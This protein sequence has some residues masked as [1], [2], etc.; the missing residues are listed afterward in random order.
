MDLVFSYFVVFLLTCYSCIASNSA[1]D[2]QEKLN[3]AIL[4]GKHYFNIPVDNYE[5][6]KSDFIIASAYN[7]VIKAEIG[8]ILT[9]YPGYGVT[10]HG[11]RNITISGFGV[12]SNPAAFTQ[13]VI[14]N[15]NEKQLMIEIIL[16]DSFP[17]PDPIL[18][19][20]FANNSET[21]V[22]FWDASTKEIIQ[23]QPMYTPLKSFKQIGPRLYQIFIDTLPK[24]PKIGDMVTIS[25]RIW[26]DI[27]RPVPTFYKGVYQVYDSYNVISKNVSI[28]GGGNMGILEWGGDG[29]H[30]YDN[31][32]LIRRPNPPYP[33]RLLSSNLDAF[34]SF[35]LKRGSLITNCEFAYMGDDFVNLHNRVFI[36]LKVITTTKG[37]TEVQFVDPTDALPDLQG[38]SMVSTV[39]YINVGEVLSFYHINSRK[40]LGAGIIATRPKKLSDPTIVESARKLFTIINEPPYSANILPV[41]LKDIGVYQVSFTT[42]LV[43]PIKE[44]ET[45]IQYDSHSSMGTVIRDSYFHNSYCNTMRLQASNTIIFNNTFEHAAL[46]FNIVF[47][48]PWLEGSLG[49]HNVSIIGNTLK[50]IGGCTDE[51]S[52]FNIDPDIKDVTIKD[53][54]II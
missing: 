5:F 38:N 50:S 46:G 47:D 43:K 31:V 22:I 29:G 48:Q 7:L 32:K 15:I 16:S 34:H 23:G 11:C 25:P 1:R 42:P 8:A 37:I 3:D 2:L 39:R 52:C 10:I 26:S 33:F 17:S 13:G 27:H 51:K 24:V 35:S 49:I 54:K 20:Y 12:D 14:S 28:Y 18:T 41:S 21:K 44:I 9:F 36:V 53:N 45:F 19:P 6:G 40:P 30:T 4:S